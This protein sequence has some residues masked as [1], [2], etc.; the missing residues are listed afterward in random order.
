MVAVDPGRWMGERGALPGS[1][2]HPVCPTM[3]I[4]ASLTWMAFFL[5]ESAAADKANWPRFRGPDGAGVAADQAVPL[6]LDESSRAWSVPLPGPG[7]SSPVVWGEK[8]FVTSENRMRGL[9]RL[10]CFHAEDGRSLWSRAVNAGL[11]RTHKMNNTAAA[12]PAVAQ[13]LVVFSWYDSGRKVAVLSAFTHGGEKR[14]NYDI[15]EFKGAHGLNI[16]PV[17]HDGHVFVAHLHQRGGFVVSLNAHT[18]KTAWKRNYPE[19]SPKTTYMTPLIRKLHGAAGSRYEVVVSS[20]SIGVR[21]LDVR[22]GR[23]LWSLP[24]IFDERCI[25]SPVDIL[26][27]S[28][29]ED[30]LLTVGCKRE[31]GNNVFLAVRP[32][33][34]RGGSAEVV[35]RLESFAPYVPTPVSDGKTLYVMADRGVLQAVDPMTGKPRWEKKFPANFYASPLLIGGQLFCLSR[36][37]EVYAIAVGEEATILARSDLRPG[38]EVTWVDA[39]PAVANDSL[40]VRMGARLDCYRNRK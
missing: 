5:L 37:G 9:V 12:T 28:G 19:G 13:D 23:E 32:A 25:V 33:D 36:D 16:V 3:R 20:T 11:Y 40:Y 14:W 26:A 22:D 10:H 18:G 39:T 1:P 29:K 8:V 21:G 2:K 31:G 7:S 34:A 35:W 15:G 17:I 24:G 6:K 4:L 27:G 30:S 38:E